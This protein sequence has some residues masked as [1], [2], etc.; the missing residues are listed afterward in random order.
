VAIFINNTQFWK[1]A[2]ME[3]VTCENVYDES[4]RRLLEYANI[5]LATEAIR[6]I[7]GEDP[8]KEKNYKTKAEQVRFSL[9]QAKEYFEA[10]RTSSLFTQPNHLYYG[11]VALSTA[12][13]VLRGDGDKSLDRLRQSKKI[14]ATA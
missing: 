11:A 2:I 14:V 7:H 8:K 6:E 4:W 3:W 10:A 1:C 9:L 5:E 12:C 13:M